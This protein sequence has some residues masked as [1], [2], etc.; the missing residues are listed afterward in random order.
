MKR[1]YNQFLQFQLNSNL[2]ISLV[3]V[4]L[5]LATQVQIGDGLQLRPFLLLIF[6]AC[7]IEY[8]LHRIV[9]YYALP[10]H[11]RQL[12]YCWLSN[13]LMITWGLIL[14]SFPVIIYSLINANQ[15]SILVFSVS[16]GIALSY[17]IP[18]Q[19]F[20]GKLSLRNIPYLKTF[21]VALVWTFITVLIPAMESDR[22]FTYDTI[23]FIA[24]GRFLLIFSLAL[25]FDIRDIEPDSEAAIQTIPI[26]LGKRPVIKL[27]TGLLILFVFIN[28][29][30]PAI[31][32]INYQ[33]IAAL[34]FALFLNF[35]VY[36]H[37][38]RVSPYYYT[39]FLDGSLFVY[40]VLVIIGWLIFA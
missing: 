3:A 39:V 40:S 23:I 16:A 34:L 25:L 37:K 27:V 31:N 30:N 21:L 1:L 28:L 4:S 19:S 6:G 32:G 8:N 2:I 14:F 22:K 11:E 38:I 15:A 9:K 18:L 12:R 36:S 10:G 7:F 24:A 29:F 33:F 13:N 17:S 26:A 5:S 35:L 20:F